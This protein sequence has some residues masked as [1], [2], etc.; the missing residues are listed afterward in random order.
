M[1]AGVPRLSASERKPPLLQPLWGRLLD[2]R[3]GAQG[4]KF[5]EWD[6]LSRSPS[7]ADIPGFMSTCLGRAICSCPAGGTGVCRQP[8]RDRRQEVG[9][10]MNW[11][12]REREV[13]PGCGRQC[14]R[15]RGQHQ[16]EIAL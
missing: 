9:R 4:V 2:G 7:K 12:L 16:P 6:R 11:K 8:A 10:K 5:R 14:A 15:G 1:L 13:E 3:S